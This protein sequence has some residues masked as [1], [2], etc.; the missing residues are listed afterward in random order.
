MIGYS[1]RR[2]R[3]I[4]YPIRIEWRETGGKAEV[5]NTHWI[6][7]LFT[8]PPVRPGVWKYTNIYPPGVREDYEIH[9][10]A[11]HERFEGTC[12]VRAQNFPK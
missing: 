4:Q 7:H 8:E 10:D 11:G 2:D 9:Y 6:E 1:R 3:V 5:V 12:R